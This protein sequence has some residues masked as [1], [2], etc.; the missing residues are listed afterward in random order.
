MLF[1]VPL[2]REINWCRIEI[3]VWISNYIHAKQLDGITHSHP[4]TSTAIEVRIWMRNYI[5]DIITDVITCPSFD[6]SQAMLVNGA[7]V[8]CSSHW[9]HMIDNAFDF[10]NQLAWVFVITKIT[11]TVMK[12]WSSWSCLFIGCHSFW[13]LTGTTFIIHD[14]LNQ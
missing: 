5:P 7:G 6:L 10:I 4:Q 9:R 11:I 3:R 14:W 2:L 8:S 12:M 13:N 1:R